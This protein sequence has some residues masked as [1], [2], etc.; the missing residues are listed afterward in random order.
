M[1][2]AIHRIILA[3]FSLVCFSTF[4]IG[5]KYRKLR[6]VDFDKLELT[7]NVYNVVQTI[8]FLDKIY[9]YIYISI[10]TDRYRQGKVPREKN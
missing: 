8:L 6:V 10:T 3:H 1:H 5:T 2:V 7:E 9:I 4:E